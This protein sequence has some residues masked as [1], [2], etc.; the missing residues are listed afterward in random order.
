MPKQTVLQTLLIEVDHMMIEVDYMMI[1]VDHMM[2]IE[3]D[4][5]MI[6]E[7][8]QNDDN[9]DQNYDYSNGGVSWAKQ[10][11]M[12]VIC[13]TKIING[14]GNNKNCGCDER[15]LH[16]FSPSKGSS[17]YK[18]D[19]ALLS[20]LHIIMVEVIIDYHNGDDHD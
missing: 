6:I 17:I 13:S 15:C 11:K 16:S 7:V 5:M 9:D 3:V 1:K 18:V 14:D 19:S 8:E 2:M 12:A 20:R 10:V 4:H